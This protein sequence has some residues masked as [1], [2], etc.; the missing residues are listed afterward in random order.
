MDQIRQRSEARVAQDSTFQ[1]VL[2]N[3]QRLKEQRDHSEYPLQLDAYQSL[4]KEQEKEA[5]QFDGLFDEE[6]N[7]NVANLDVDLSHIELDESRK[8]RNDDWVQSV[9]KDIYI[10][11]TMNIMHD[12]IELK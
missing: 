12:L 11:E 4:V 1:K 3:A 9:T 10:R 5:K 8:A 2:K 6:V 7:H